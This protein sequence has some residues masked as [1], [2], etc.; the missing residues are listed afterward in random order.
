MCTYCLV[1]TNDQAFLFSIC[2]LEPPIIIQRTVFWLCVVGEHKRSTHKTQ[3][4]PI[5]E[6]RKHVPTVDCT[7][8]SRIVVNFLIV[9][10]PAAVG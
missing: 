10:N 9:K 2:K 5:V 6:R 3:F 8:V 1:Q 4:Q 7:I